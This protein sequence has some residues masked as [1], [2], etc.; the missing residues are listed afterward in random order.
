MGDLDDP[1]R[2][3]NSYHVVNGSYTD[4]TAVLEGFTITAGNANHNNTYVYSWGGGLYSRKGHLTVA[5]CKFIGNSAIPLR[6]M[7]DNA[8]GGGGAVYNEFSNPTIIDCN[9]TGN[10]APYSGTSS[11]HY[12]GG[13]IYNSESI[14]TISGCTFN[15]NEAYR[16]GAM[17]NYS[18]APII[19]NSTF[20]ENTANNSGGGVYGDGVMYNACLLYTSPSPRDRS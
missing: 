10:R 7:Q 12:G 1:S 8:G 16:G 14:P 13:A 20:S 15:G 5:N 4:K 9:F 19:T 11:G 17:C 6:V 2:S 3:E 18:S